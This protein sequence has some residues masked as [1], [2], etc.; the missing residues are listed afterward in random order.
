MFVLGEVFGPGIQDLSYGIDKMSFRVFDVIVGYHGNRL[1]LDHDEVLELAD[2]V[3]I[4]HVPILYEGPFSKQTMLEFTDGKETVSGD[5][6]HVREGVVIKPTVERTDGL[7]GRVILK[8]VS[9]DYLT[10]KGKATEYQ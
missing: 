3:G 10:R 8:S 9:G 2:K 1:F 4:S 7:I 5:S 6:S